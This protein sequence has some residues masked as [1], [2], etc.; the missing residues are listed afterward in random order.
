MSEKN[1]TAIIVAAGKG[2]RFA[3]GPRAAKQ[4]FRIDGIPLICHTV[5]PFNDSS[6]VSKIVLVVPANK[7]K[8]CAG[9]VKQYGFSKV[10]AVVGGGS[11]RARSVYNGLKAAPTGTEIVL[12]HDGARPA[13][14]K[15]LI[16]R[17]AAAAARSGAA[18]PVISC[19]DTIKQIRGSFVT[20]TV[21]RN[22][23][24]RAQTPQGFRFKLILE[25]F[26]KFKKKIDK[27]TDDCSLF[28]LA[29]KKIK[30][31][32]GDGDNI[33][34]TKKSDLRLLRSDWRTGIG[35]DIHRLV[36]KRR[37]I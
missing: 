26:E 32:E 1:I 34:I 21:E 30:F 16:C 23:L 2:K 6:V 29:G 35:Y 3:R 36:K 19:E 12:I 9:L 27:V 14:S 25:C 24:V 11:S 22:G 4:F 37:L 33:K 17:V 13:V 20:G 5:R 8:Y 10:C 31:V 15:D 7:I 28:E 18:V